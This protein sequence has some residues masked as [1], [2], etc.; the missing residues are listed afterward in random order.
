MW[1][2]IHCYDNNA[3]YS[4]SCACIMAYIDS[5]YSLLND[6]NWK[7]KHCVTQVS[8]SFSR[9]RSV[10]MC[11]QFKVYSLSQPRSDSVARCGTVFSSVR[12]SVFVSIIT[13][14]PFEIS[15]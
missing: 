5:I 3:L 8:L 11:N 2:A 15:P 14:E 1:T 10:G 6:T 12:L 13:A 4:E 9:M 7:T